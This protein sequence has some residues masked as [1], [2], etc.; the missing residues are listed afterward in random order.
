MESRPIRANS[1][2]EPMNRYTDLVDFDSATFRRG[3]NRVTVNFPIKMRRGNEKNRNRKIKRRIERIDDRK[4]ADRS[5]AKRSALVNLENFKRSAAPKRVLYREDRSWKELS[6]E[7]VVELA[8]SAFEARRSPVVEISVDGNEY[9]VD[10]YR[11]LMIDLSDGAERSVAWIDVDGKCFF[12]KLFVHDDNDDDD[13]VDDDEH[14]FDTNSRV[15]ACKCSNIG[16]IDIEIKLTGSESLISGKRKREVELGFEQ[17]SEGDLDDTAISSNSGCGDMKRQHSFVDDV[18]VEKPSWPNARLIRKDQKAYSAVRDLFMEGMKSVN[19]GVEI[20]SI[21]EFSCAGPMERARWEL[22]HKNMENMKNARGVSNTIFAW[23]SA[24]KKD[25]VSILGHGFGSPSKVSGSQAHGIGVYLYP[26]RSPQMSHVFAE[27]DENGECHVLLCRVVLGNVEKVG[28]GSQQNHPSS[29]RFDSGVDDVG[30]PKCYVVWSA[31]MNGH[32]LPEC[33][34]SYKCSDRLQGRENRADFTKWVPNASSSVVVKL[35]S[36]LGSVLPRAKLEEVKSLCRTYKVG[37]M[38]KLS[39]IKN[40]RAIAGDEM[41]R[42]AICEFASRFVKEPLKCRGLFLVLNQRLGVK[43]SQSGG[44]ARA[45]AKCMSYGDVLVMRLSVS[46][47]M[48]WLT[49]LLALVLL[50]KVSEC[51]NHG[52]ANDDCFMQQGCLDLGAISNHGCIFS[53][54]SNPVPTFCLSLCVVSLVFELFEACASRCI[55]SLTLSGYVFSGYVMPFQVTMLCC[56]STI[57]QLASCAVSLAFQLIEE[58]SILE[59]QKYERCVECGYHTYF[60]V[61]F[62]IN[63]M[64]RGTKFTS[65]SHTYDSYEER[66]GHDDRRRTTAELLCRVRS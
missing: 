42:Y 33:L 60:V 63:V 61:S 58:K 4:G 48:R 46:R 17:D 56:S 1:G 9:L 14:S 21:H 50:R 39:F 54:I 37:K 22:F 36:K 13:V 41:L 18:K 19:A 64:C 24:S 2:F 28:T 59:V 15:R 16:K 53:A 55:C 57:R 10:F 11:M 47:T 44:S 66:P 35:F 32:I 38:E 49:A 26:A 52:K 30:N 25:I 45:K 12:P 6:E 7:M 40:L 20:T 3:Q 27:E 8:K 43:M 23:H 29:S 62:A 51:F 34:V 31:K 65:P 5:T